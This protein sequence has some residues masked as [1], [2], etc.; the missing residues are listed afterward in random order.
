MKQG[1]RNI[2]KGLRFL[3]QQ[4]E[5]LEQLLAAKNISFTDLVHTLIAQEFLR[6]KPYVP[7]EHDVLQSV[8]KAK[9]S[10]PKSSRSQAPFCAFDPAFLHELGCI[11]NSI[12]QTA[13]SLNILCDRDPKDQ[14]DFSF[15][16]CLA[17]LNQVQAE[18]H[19]HLKKLP[20]ITRFEHAVE[21]GW[22]QVLRY[23][24]SKRTEE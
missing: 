24:M 21:R 16:S 14:T 17:V 8:I 5:Q 15:I 2:V 12:N 19:H 1:N 4:V 7:Q 20:L 13:K 9:P 11:G 10:R 22:E 3:D 18:L 6:N 23:V